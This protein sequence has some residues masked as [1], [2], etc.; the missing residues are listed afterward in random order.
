MFIAGTGV[1]SLRLLLLG[2]FRTLGSI[3][4]ATLGAVLNAAG[5]QSAAN[6]VIAHTG[7][8]FYTTAANKHYRVLLKSVAF[9]GYVGV[10]FL[11]VGQAHAG[12]LTHCRIRLFGGSG[13]NAHT[14]A[15]TLRT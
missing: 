6:Y 11:T 5:I 2:G 8:V 3:F 7:K 13:V 12:N 15:A 9:A 14:Y 10:Y 1:P 4:R